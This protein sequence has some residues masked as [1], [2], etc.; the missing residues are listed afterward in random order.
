MADHA[1]ELIDYEEEEEET[2]QPTTTTATTGG[3]AAAASGEAAAG[4]GDAEQDKANKGSYV[5]VHS[6]SFRDFL[7]KPE[8]LRAIVDCGFEH[9]S[10]VQQET[11]PAAINGND[12]LC[13]AKSGLGKTA[14]FVLATLNKIT[15]VPGTVSAIVLCHAREL[16]YQIKNEYMRF[17]KYLPDIKTEVFYG[18]VSIKHDQEI[19]GDKEKCPNIIVGTPGRILA[20][21]REKT[22]RLS[23]V[24]SFVID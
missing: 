2:L 15:P 10:E 19:L 7:M 9:P 23:N 6:T 22:L 3:G 4:E 5:G 24:S 21:V 12:V 1:D 20:L 11:I 16:A 18:G 8:L 14:V 17:S 13:Q